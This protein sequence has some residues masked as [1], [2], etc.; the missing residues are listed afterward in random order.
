MS[1]IELRA[2]SDHHDR[3]RV[4]METMRA[5][6]V[7]LIDKFQVDFIE[8]K[9]NQYVDDAGP[10]HNMGLAMARHGDERLDDLAARDIPL[11][12]G[13]LW[14]DSGEDYQRTCGSRSPTGDASASREAD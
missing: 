1:G 4:A 11:F 6:T 9:Q 5:T 3:V 7:T 10:D 14:L 12:F 8:G 2:E 13:R